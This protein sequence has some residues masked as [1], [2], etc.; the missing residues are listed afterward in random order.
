ME[1]IFILIPWFSPAYKAGGPV[2]SIANLVELMQGEPFEFNIFCSIKD[3]DGT[4]LKDITAD[5]WIPYNT[6]TSVFYSSDNNI[7][8]LLK[9]QIKKDKPAWVYINGIFD[10]NYNLKPILYC[11]A[12]SKI[13]SPRGMLQK[14]AVGGKALKKKPFLELLK[15]SGRLNDARWHATNEEEKNDIL[16]YFPRAKDIVIVPNIPK[17]PVTAIINSNKK[18]GDL[19]LAYLS[20]IAKKKNLHLI[21][22]GMIN[23]EMQSVV[24]DIYGPVKDKGYWEKKCLP[25]ISQLVGRVNYQGGLDP[26]KVQSTLAAYD[27]LVLLTKGENFGH[28]IYESLSAGRPALISHFT[29]WNDLEKKPAGW[30]IDINDEEEIVSV[31]NRLVR[32]DNAEHRL[33]CEGAFGVA[34]DY[35]EK[36]EFTKAYGEMFRSSPGK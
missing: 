28:A 6:N 1:K 33:F 31:L 30:N 20:L 18:Q 22:Q 3:L 21:L 34:Q 24:L 25:L 26:A 16:K 5:T 12:V 2:Q 8:A 27:A 9:Q 11:A 10:W 32:M 19:K 29:P 23:A 15:L 36:N 13:I 35:Y 4:I 14:G 17:R 7:L